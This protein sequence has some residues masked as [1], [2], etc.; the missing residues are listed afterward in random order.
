MTGIYAAEAMCAVA[1]IPWQVTNV[2]AESEP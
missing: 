2:P 1:K